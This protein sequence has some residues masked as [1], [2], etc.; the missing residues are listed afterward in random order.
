MTFC[1]GP[2]FRLADPTK[3]T[4]SWVLKLLSIAPKKPKTDLKMTEPGALKSTLSAFIEKIDF[5]R[6]VYPRYGWPS[7]PVSSGGMV[8]LNTINHI[9]FLPFWLR[10]KAFNIRKYLLHSSYI[11]YSIN[12]T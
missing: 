5:K 12:R 7:P 6:A 3:G 8:S 1:S 10:S 2:C 4:T 11:N 9:D